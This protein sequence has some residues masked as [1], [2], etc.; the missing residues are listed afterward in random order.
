MEILVLSQSKAEK[1]I[2]ENNTRTL[3]VISITDPGQPLADIKEDKLTKSVF[4]MSFYDLDTDFVALNGKDV[5]PCATKDDINGLKKFIDTLPPVDVLVV[6]CAAGYSRSA[7]VG[8]AVELYLGMGNTIWG[9]SRY[10]PNAHVYRLCLQEFGIQKT[11]DYYQ[12][13]FAGQME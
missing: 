8:A 7:G 1:Y 4:R 12:E 13:L 10:Y 5:I 3:A 6:H 9:N 2:K 11:E